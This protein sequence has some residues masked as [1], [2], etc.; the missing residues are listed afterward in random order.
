MYLI[1][2]LDQKLNQMNFLKDNVIQLMEDRNIIEEVTK[3]RK[4]FEGLNAIVLNLKPH[5]DDSSHSQR[6]NLDSYRY[7]EITVFNEFKKQMKK[8][9]DNICNRLDDMR[10]TID[11]DLVINMRKRA[12]VVELKALEGK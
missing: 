12:S 8:E 4:K 3:L 5:S 11:E 6:A 9:L 2:N 1:V 7:L 10:I